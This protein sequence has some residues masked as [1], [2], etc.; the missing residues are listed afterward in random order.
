MSRTTLYMRLLLALIAALL[1]AA[2]ASMGRPEGGPRDVMPPMF[3]RSNPAPGALNVKR[4]K[5]EVEFN[6]NVQIKDAMSKVVISPAQRTT[7]SVSAIGRRIIVELRDSL[8]PNTTYTIDFSDAITDLNEG[9]IL[10]GFSTDFSTGD[11]IDT[12]RISGM[13]FQASNL[14]PAQG[15]LVGVYSDL[16][17]TAVRTL[18]ME[19]ITK[20]NQYGQFTL[21]NLKEG[22]YRIFA[23]NDQ[24]RDYHWDRTEDI[25]FY[26]MTITPTATHTSRTDTL[27][28]AAGTDSI[29]TVGYTE[30]FPNDIL[31]TWFNENYKAQYLMKYERLERNK[32]FF[33]MGAPADTLPVITLLNGPRAGETIDR[34]SMLNASP[35]LDSLEYWISDPA[36]IA[37]DSILLEARYMRTDTLDQLSWTTD[38]LKLIMRGS[39]KKTEE[40][41]K[42]KKEEADTMPPEPTYLKYTAMTG[43]VQ[44]IN[45]PLLFKSLEPIVSFDSTAVRLEILDDTVWTAIEAPRIYFP[46]PLKPMEMRADYEWEPDMKYRLTVD[47]AAI[48][49]IS[50]DV[51]KEFTHEFTVQKLEEYCSIIFNI[52]GLE[53][54]GVVE[55]L[56]GND[57][58]VRQATVAGGR[59][60]IEYVKPG[61]YYARLYVDRNENG[62]YDQGSFT[63]SIQPEDVYYYP[64]KLNLK[65]NWDIEQSWNINELPIDM[66][67]PNEI[68]KN[69]PKKQPGEIDRDEDEEDEDEEFDFF[70]PGGN[71][72][73][74]NNRNNRNNGLRNQNSGLRNNNSN[75]FAR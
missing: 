2:C 67:K 31:L 13:V 47:S 61:N 56:T 1:M 55:L 37:Q 73:D 48:T 32:I 34:W 5:I 41:K 28:T 38:T 43:S 57:I 24:N 50:G 25:A 16:S 60:E 42:N 49:G 69:K 8:I 39:K 63:D 65:K 36:L 74:R 35:T 75:T 18:P 54:P 59:A 7:P 27:K 14:E 52:S 46:S 22:T 58:P 23:I 4:T 20:T 64:K 10:D 51:N 29:V 33:Q 45:M 17:D 40:K 72:N 68:K 12:L 19:R 15:M 21:R 9:N 3:V 71:P 66:Q 70:N 6:E 11:V 26:D 62:R 30:F 53:G 44:D